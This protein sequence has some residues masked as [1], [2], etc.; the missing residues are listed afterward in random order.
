MTTLRDT[1]KIRRRESML[2]AARELFIDTGYN[3]TTMDAIAQRAEIGVATVYTY[4]G[5]KESLFADLARRD[6]TELRDEASEVLG[7]ISDDPGDAVMELL[8]VY[9]KVR[10]YI[11]S[12]VINDF[13]IG[14]KIVGPLRDTARWM[15]GWKVQQIGS[16]LELA[17][18]KGNLSSKL[19]AIEAAEIVNELF[20]Q[21]YQRYQSLESPKKAFDQLERRVRLLFVNWV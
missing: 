5:N 6:M 10:N 21:Y 7:K 18:E 19:P 2:Q 17:Q 12:N 15:D 8:N 13:T 20:N 9:D 16:A 14:S 1:Q 3:K 11:T 4:F